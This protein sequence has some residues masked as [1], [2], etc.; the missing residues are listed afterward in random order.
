MKSGTGEEVERAY[1]L[2]KT[3]GRPKTM[4]YFRTAPF[5]TADLK[6]IAQFRKVVRFRKALEKLGILYWT[7][8]APLDFERI[9]R[10][11]LMRRILSD[12]EIRERG[13]L[14]RQAQPESEPNRPSVFIAYS[15]LD[16]DHARSVYRV[17][18]G[19][20][21]RM[22]LDEQDLVSGQL[23][24]SEVDSAISRTDV[25][26]LLL[27]SRTDLLRGFVGKEIEAGTKLAAQSGGPLLV[28]VRLDQME[29]PKLLREVQ[30][31]NYFAPDGPERPIKAIE[32]AW[33]DR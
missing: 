17:I 19:A 33:S 20:G 32:S 16:R 25:L 22:W 2:F 3:H 30:W 9:V 15:H 28:P 21:Y 23:W 18:E 12:T 8:E 27:P 13:P 31:V 14:D 11:H 4:F 26:V 10:E 24:H 7:Y 5:Y 1:N 6:E 29:P